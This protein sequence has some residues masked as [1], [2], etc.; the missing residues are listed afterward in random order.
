MATQNNE[1]RSIQMSQ[2][3]TF[4]RKI[5]LYTVRNYAQMLNAQQRSH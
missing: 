4:S 2:V 1:N 3:T 5:I